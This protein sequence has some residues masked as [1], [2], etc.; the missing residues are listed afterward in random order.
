M[1]VIEVRFKLEKETKGAPRY[2]EVDE[3]IAIASNLI[4]PS[5]RANSHMPP[6]AIATFEIRVTFRHLSTNSARSSILTSSCD[7]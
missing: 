4:A 7:I 6:A 3:K 1:P 5:V 2:Q